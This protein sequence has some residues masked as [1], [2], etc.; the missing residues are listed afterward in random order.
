MQFFTSLALDKS[1]GSLSLPTL[2][3][4]LQWLIYTH[5]DSYNYTESQLR[6]RVLWFPGW[7]RFPDR[8]T[9]WGWLEAAFHFPGRV[10]YMFPKSLFRT[11]CIFPVAHN[12]ALLVVLLL[13]VPLPTTFVV[14][15]TRDSPTFDRILHP[16][17]KDCPSP[18]AQESDAVAFSP[19][20]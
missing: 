8:L 15:P 2:E 3:S 20:L 12:A 11:V 18:L 17:Q 5:Y 10:R 9:H 19:R 7:H 6:G 14:V 16:D 1:F 13:S 4:K